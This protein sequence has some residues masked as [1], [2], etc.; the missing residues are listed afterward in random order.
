M[1]INRHSVS[2]HGYRTFLIV[3]LGQLVSL[4]GTGMTRF[5]LIIWAYQQ[6]GTATTLALM[7]FFA[8]GSYVL[9]SPVAG[10]YID[11]F[12][13][14]L[15]MMLSDLGAGVVTIAV[16]VLYSG[17]SLA[18]WHLYLAQTALGALDAFQVP[19]YTAATTLL[20]PKNQYARAS[21][22]RSLA[23]SLSEV[24]APFAAGA[25]LAVI[26]I[27]G[28]LVI[29]IVT[30]VFAFTTLLM[31]RFPPVPVDSEQE[32]RQR[33]PLTRQLTF[34]LRYIW[35]RPGL[36]G[37]MLIFSGIVLFAALTYFSILPAMILARS[38]GDE[39]ALASVQAV[40]GI[41]G[42]VGGIVLTA[43][44]GPKRRIHGVLLA[45]ALSFLLGDFLFATGQALPVWVLAAFA[46]TFFIPFIDGS[47]RAIW[48]SK[49]HPAV[50]GRVFSVQTM[51]QQAAR[52]FGYLAGGLLADHLFEPALMP[53][54]ALA[55]TFGWLV[56]IGPGAGMGVMFLCTALLGFIMSISG[57]FIPAVRNVEVELPDY[58]ADDTPEIPPDIA[59]ASAS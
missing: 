38:G 26:G 47:N 12:D 20:I 27:A 21:G 3:W 23:F 35:Q 37:L 16:L 34:G 10:I 6:T 2:G 43:W 45:T 9:V 30:F 39:M 41:G 36:R 8:F 48:Q 55:D 33:E 51:I 57:Y 49:V 56:G 19:A 40:L 14:R 53:S 28:V 44:G 31:V 58:D 32:S 24:G 59:P 5:A 52:P 42:V 18:I 25:L 22:M 29:D 54:G 1:N 11:R 46:T 4:V 50:Q 7:G 17:D 15:V 13:R